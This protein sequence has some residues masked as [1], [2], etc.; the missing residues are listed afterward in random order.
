MTQHTSHFASTTPAGSSP[1]AAIRNL[2]AEL[3]T[4]IYVRKAG[5]QLLLERTQQQGGELQGIVPAIQ[6]QN[7]GDPGF[8]RD[9][10]VC[11]AYYAGAMANGINSEE[12][13][14]ALGQ[15]KMLGSFGAGGLS[16]ERVATAIARIKQALPQ[17]PFAI[18]LLHNPGEPDWE[19]DV[20]R[21]CIQND[22]QLI[23][24]S[25]YMKLT[26][27]IVYYRVTGLERQAD[28]AIKRRHRIVAKVSRAE[29]AQHFIKPAPDDILRRLL[30]QG[31]ISP[32]QA[33]M[34]RQVPMADD[35]TVEADS[36]GHTDN[37]ILSCALPSIVALRDRI[38]DN[39]G[40]AF[41]V[42]IGA[43][44]GLGNP[45]AVYAAF[46]LGAAFVCTGSINQACREAATSTEVKKLLVKARS[47]DVAMAPSADMFEMGAK[48]QVLKGG[49]LYPMRAQKLYSLYKQ[50]DCLDD[51]PE[52]E[53]AALETS[54]FRQPLSQVWQETEAF[55]H[56]RGNTQLIKAANENP[57]KKM[58]LVFQWYL[59]QSSRW[60]ISNDPDRAM[61]YQ[62]WCGPAMGAVNEWLDQSPYAAPENRSV[63]ALGQL[64]MQGAAYLARTM[65][66][67]Q[68]GVEIEGADYGLR[69]WLQA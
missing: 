12:M 59:G 40:E 15:Q 4:P 69:P 24:A 60:A 3:D 55:F 43:A 45:Q 27:A 54:I 22:V 57:K 63:C 10:G 25:A 28:G 38:A 19:M 68:C 2:L 64:M 49:T 32:E 21:L 36:G 7:L 61:D 44:G 52:S 6:P 8:L 31:L 5:G 35:L 1:W 51:I 50:Y 37:G 46:S 16:R 66:L 42:R 47:N 9:H 18:N 58:A 17:G 34:A 39:A 33:E 53:L 30:E 62:I 13:V 56:K 11:M 20:V 48:V 41:R 14:I 65:A 67:K 26:P 29:V 23:E